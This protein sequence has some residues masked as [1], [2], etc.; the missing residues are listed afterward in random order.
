MPIEESKLEDMTLKSNEKDTPQPAT[1]TVPTLADYT[2]PHKLKIKGFL[3]QLPVIVL[4][5]TVSTHNFMSSKQRKSGG[6][7]R[8]PSD[9][10]H[11]TTLGEGTK[12]RIQWLLNSNSRVSGD[13][14]KGD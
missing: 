8:E 12:R 1:R 2:N 10:D 5:D 4:I 7:T 9:Y 11:N 3:E 13:K 6:F 14:A